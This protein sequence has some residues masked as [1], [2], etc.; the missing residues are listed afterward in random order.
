M[1]RWLAL[2]ALALLVIG[3]VLLR[4]GPVDT[5]APLDPP[6]TTARET[7]N[8]ESR[9]DSPARLDLLQEA[10]EPA[11]TEARGP[12]PV[13]ERTSTY[14][15]LVGR[16][17]LADGAPHANQTARFSIHAA[18][19]ANL[20]T[21]NVRTTD[22]GRFE[23]RTVAL[24][25][26]PLEPLSLTIQ[27]RSR[28]ASVLMETLDLP[29]L[30]RGK[31]TD[32]GDIVLE[33][34]P[35]GVICRLVDREGR[36]I[37]EPGD[38]GPD[39]ELWG[40]DGLVRHDDDRERGNG[41][42]LQFD[43][44]EEAGWLVLD[45]RGMSIFPKPWFVDATQP[46]AEARAVGG[47]AGV[48]VRIGDD[49]ELVVAHGGTIRGSVV[50][51]AGLSTGVDRVRVR[52]MEDTEPL[53]WGRSNKDQVVY[54]MIAE[55][56]RFEAEAVDAGARRVEFLSNQL[57]LFSVENVEVG[58]EEVVDDPR[59]QAVDFGVLTRTI[60]L[61][62]VDPAGALVPDA[63]ALVGREGSYGESTRVGDEVRVLLPESATLVSAAADTDLIVHAPGF[64]PAQLTPPFQ[65]ATVTL[66]PAIPIRARTAAPFD[67]DIGSHGFWLRLRRVDGPDAA[68]WLWATELP[69]GG[70]GTEAAEITAPGPGRYELEVMVKTRAGTLFM[71][72][73]SDRYVGTGVFLEVG[74]EHAASPLVIDVPENLVRFDT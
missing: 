20:H 16:L 26:A 49:V 5:P 31:R 41:V 71:T 40:P 37:V 53:T 62:V 59:L 1:A 61:R 8:R 52:A 47:R 28:G 73:P 2:L 6:E 55:D 24:D 7:L 22:E 29:P 3:T 39:V 56:G 63:A 34:R 27:E 42:V 68:G 25:E 64:V 44:G 14:P 46:G 48:A 10:P 66:E 12:D 69:F 43:G 30:E 74:P 50:R 33:L 15:I 17:V 32:L 18:S 21:M 9:L 60:A 54:A 11:R 70:D 35:I 58:L 65:D 51:D 4:G 57:L 13:T 23:F 72:T 45:P 19:G 67:G 38:L 36:P